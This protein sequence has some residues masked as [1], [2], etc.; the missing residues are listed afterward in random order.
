M[1][2][3]RP[4]YHG[5]GLGT[6]GKILCRNGHELFAGGLLRKAITYISMMMV[7]LRSME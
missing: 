6:L 5:Q 7:R 4:S 1:A 3:K 2:T